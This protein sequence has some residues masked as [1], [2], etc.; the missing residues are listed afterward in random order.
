MPTVKPVDLFDESNA[1]K[2]KDAKWEKP[3]Q[4]YRGVLVE[5]RVA[6]GGGLSEVKG[7]KEKMVYSL[8]QDDGEIVRVWGRSGVP[9]QVIPGLERAKLGQEVG[10]RYEKDLPSAQKGYHPTKVIRVYL[11]QMR[12]EALDAYHAGQ[13]FDDANAADQASEP[14]IALEDLPT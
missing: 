12:P 2:P 5:K 13:V 11:G 1:Y 8:L 7:V 4:S 14:R 3:G 10:L 6:P 9:R